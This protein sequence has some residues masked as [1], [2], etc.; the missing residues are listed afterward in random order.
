MHL[1]PFLSLFNDYIWYLRTVNSKLVMDT[2]MDA[3]ADFIEDTTASTIARYFVE[4]NPLVEAM[5]CECAYSST[6]LV[7]SDP[8]VDELDALV[9]VTRLVAARAHD[10]L[11]PMGQALLWDP[12]SS[13][14]LGTAES[15]SASP[16]HGTPMM[17][18]AVAPSADDSPSPRE[19]AARLARFNVEVMVVRQPP[20]IS[21]PPKLLSKRTLP[22]RSTR[23][24]TQ[25]MDHIPTSKSGEV[26]L[27]KKLGFLEQRRLPLVPSVRTTPTSR[28]TCRL[29]MLKPSTS[30]S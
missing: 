12:T 4:P 14:P 1:N 29:Q 9:D 28:A 24:A 11:Y 16:L 3:P 7:S 19:V 22:L 17:T 25:Q 2:T 18:G 15:P 23:I 13:A 21:S 5:L 26:L 10:C 27:T 30:C 8:M 20:L 6:Q